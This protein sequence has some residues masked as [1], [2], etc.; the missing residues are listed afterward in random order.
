MHHA[1]RKRGD[2]MYQGIRFKLSSVTF[3]LVAIITSASSLIVV[4]IMDDFILDSLIKRGMSIGKSAS[5]AASYSL[6]SEDSL[7]LDNLA[8][9]L[10]E[11][12]ED[13]IYVAA[14]DN[15]GQIRAHST[16]GRSGKPFRAAG[17]EII[18]TLE[19]GSTVSRAVKGGVSVLEIKMPIVF[20]GKKLGDIYLGIDSVTLV[21]AQSKARRNIM[22]VSLAV[23]ALGVVGTF[24]LSGFITT[25][26]KKLA[27]AVSEL[28]LGEYKKEI[29]VV[30]KDELGELI[31]NF[32]EMARIITEQNSRLGK[33]AKELEES[34]V[35]TVKVLAAAIDARDPYTLGHSTR[36]ANIALLLGARLGLSDEELKDLEIACLFHDVGKI[37]TPDSI[38]QKRGA[39]SEEENRL[40][41]RHVEDGAEILKLADSLHKHIPTVLHHHEWY[42]GK[43]YPKGLKGDEIPL[44][45]SIISIVDAY[46]AM[47][48]SR[49]YRYA[50]SKER[51]IEELKV[52]RGRQ[53]DPNITDIFVEVLQSHDIGH[54]QIPAEKN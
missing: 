5:T 4:R 19:D 41:M 51:A 24:F 1:K 32:N 25:P 16:L 27:V 12:Q 13:L 53:F 17:G 9:K 21:A 34:Y 6:L 40:M 10:K 23:L 37:R 14:V 45:A 52:F 39:L 22:A 47:T 43:G 26:I 33:S 20:A 30:S 49:P 28:P 18:R 36:I 44:F 48:S 38:L 7:A 2:D 15:G 46:D 35:A 29:P 50:K 11:S 42:N 8:S 3:L 54:M 31:G